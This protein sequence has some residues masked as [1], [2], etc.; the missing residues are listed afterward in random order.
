[1][2][3]VAIAIAAVF[4][5]SHTPAICAEPDGAKEPSYRLEFK[6]AKQRSKRAKKGGAS[7]NSTSETWNYKVEI[8]NRSLDAIGSLEVKYTYYI[9]TETRSG[10]SRKETTRKVAGES[11]LGGIARS[12]TATFE[13]K[14]SPLKQSEKTER[15]TKSKRGSNNKKKN[16]KAQIKVTEVREKLDGIKIEVFH[17]G[18]LIAEHVVGDAA[19]RASSGKKR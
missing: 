16:S 4:L 13:T 11:K 17:R 12:N 3:F 14:S 6:I 8:G 19:K 5:G 2:R 7:N 15:K 9:T 1:M 10:S 18:G